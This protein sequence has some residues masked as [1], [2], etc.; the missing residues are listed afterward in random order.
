MSDRPEG[1]GCGESGAELVPPS[2][3]LPLL[4]VAAQDA[5]STG[6]LGCPW[7]P[8]LVRSTGRCRQGAPLPRAVTACRLCT[9]C[10]GRL[11]SQPETQR[12]CPPGWSWPWAKQSL[13]P[14][15]TAGPED[16]K[17][18]NPGSLQGGGPARGPHGTGGWT[19]RRPQAGVLGTDRAARVVGGQRCPR[20]PRWPEPTCAGPE[21]QPS[22]QRL[23]PPP[24]EKCR[25][26]RGPRARTS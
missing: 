11:C 18:L 26:S 9:Q 21:T 2:S 19:W 5:G 14:E 4:R 8:G 10:R 22:R 13:V 7:G 17:V 6:W 25:L 20:V 15:R 12:Y 16:L 3:P 23:P 1:G 24:G